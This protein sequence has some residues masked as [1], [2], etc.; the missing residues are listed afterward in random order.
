MTLVASLKI[1]NFR[2]F[3]ERSRQIALIH[4]DDPIG[5]SNADLALADFIGMPALTHDRPDD[6]CCDQS[7]ACGKRG[8]AL[9]IFPTSLK[10]A[11]APKG[12]SAGKQSQVLIHL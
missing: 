6:H 10:N 2:K 8:R 11:Q 9:G 5:G 3:S 7:Y 4:F 12:F 1:I